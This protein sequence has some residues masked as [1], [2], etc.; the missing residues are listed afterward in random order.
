M[1]Q[2][3]Q[4]INGGPVRVVDVPRP[5]IGPTEVLVQVIATTISPGT[6]RAVTALARASLLEKARAR[7]DLVKQVLGKVKSD[8]VMATAGAVRTRLDEDMPLGYSGAGIAVE[9]GEAVEGVS[10]GQ[11]VATGGAAKA[12]H[13]EYQAVPAL[14]CVPVPDGVAARDAALS[15]IASIALHGLRL[16]ELAPGSKV[17]VVGLGPVSYTHLTLPTIYSV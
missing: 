9:V 8:G 1:K 15:T 17:V 16:G 2:V 4:A 13:A 12:N 7:P 6:E 11:L 14:L 3:V 5:T 10:P